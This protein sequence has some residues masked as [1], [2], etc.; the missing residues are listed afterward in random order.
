MKR[1]II[2]IILAVITV[3]TA[4]PSF[5]DT[6]QTV[7]DSST[8]HTKYAISTTTNKTLYSNTGHYVDHYA[9]TADSGHLSGSP[10]YSASG[11][12]SGNGSGYASTFQNHN[13][14]LGLLTSKTITYVLQS[15]SIASNKDTGRYEIQ[16]LAS[17]CGL[18]QKIKLVVKD[19]STGGTTTTYPFSRS[20]T[21][22]PRSSSVFT[23][24]RAVYRGSIS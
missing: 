13:S 14:S 2:S 6:I 5:A 22:V 11:D 9:G 7:V 20:I 18:S 24:L 3:F 1:K 12:I 10:T 19:E 4:L 21:Y 15:W 16:A 8:M 23:G 17:G